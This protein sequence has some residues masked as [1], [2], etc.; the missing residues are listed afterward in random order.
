MSKPDANALFPRTRQ[1]RKVM[2][3]DL[4][5]LGDTVHLRQNTADGFVPKSRAIAHTNSHRDEET[6]CL[7]ICFGIVSGSARIQF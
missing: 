2:V 4:D 6:G 7:R 5:F 1:A 3:L